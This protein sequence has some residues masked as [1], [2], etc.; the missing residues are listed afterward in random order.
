M[1]PTFQFLYI[2]HLLN[3]LLNCALGWWEKENTAGKRGAG[4]AQLER[5]REVLNPDARKT[6][7][8]SCC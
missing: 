3:Y 7:D 2:I 1:A 6:L 4:K 8:L 5:R